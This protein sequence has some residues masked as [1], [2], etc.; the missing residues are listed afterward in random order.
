MIEFLYSLVGV[1]VAA[2]YIPQIIKL[3]RATLPCH[4]ISVFTWVVWAYTSFVSLL[5]SLYGQETFDIYFFSANLINIVCVTTV[6][7]ITMY[8]RVKYSERPATASTSYLPLD[9]QRNVESIGENINVEGI[10][11][12]IAA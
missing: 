3:V 5:Y 10:I 1:V 9:P 12:K 11:E 8:K 6:I 7:C 2:G 4:D